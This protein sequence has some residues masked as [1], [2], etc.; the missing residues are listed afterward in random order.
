[1]VLII[2][3]EKNKLVCVQ[4]FVLKREK[5]MILGACMSDFSDSLP[6]CWIVLKALAICSK[7]AGTTDLTVTV[8]ILAIEEK[9]VWS[10]SFESKRHLLCMYC[11]IQAQA[12]RRFPEMHVPLL[13]PLACQCRSVHS[14]SYSISLGVFESR[15]FVCFKNVKNLSSVLVCHFFFVCFFLNDLYD[16]LY[17]QL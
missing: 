7:F 10:D 4:V 9:T 17:Q 16:W 5:E 11:D 3:T 15:Y 6:F 13:C 12:Q 2:I 14:L 8:F 1:M